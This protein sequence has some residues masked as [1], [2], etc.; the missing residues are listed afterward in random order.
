MY[1]SIDQNMI[2]M[3]GI[4][5]TNEKRSQ[6]KATPILE[7]CG[8]SWWIIALESVPNRLSGGVPVMFVLLVV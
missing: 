7:S 3:A 8:K 5:K 4:R 6:K 2:S 1:L